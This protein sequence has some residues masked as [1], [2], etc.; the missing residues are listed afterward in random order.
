MA[1]S[2]EEGEEKTDK[3]R[4]SV[5]SDSIKS[6]ILML[7]EFQKEKEYR[8]LKKKKKKPE[9]IMTESFLNWA[10]L[11]TY[12]FK[13]LRLMRINQKK[14]LARHNKIKL[15]KPKDRGKLLKVAR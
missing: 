12:R 10:K 15:L 6:V 2:E 8:A 1:Q 3:R 7:S 5:N 14:P 11:Q 13:K 4:I 9:E